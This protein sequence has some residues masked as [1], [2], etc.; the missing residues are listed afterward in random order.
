VIWLRTHFVAGC[1]SS[2]RPART[3]PPGRLRCGP[4]LNCFSWPMGR[5][6]G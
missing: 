2:R 4:Y 6:C 3:I 1:F 5:G